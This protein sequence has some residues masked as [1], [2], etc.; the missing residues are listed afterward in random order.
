MGLLMKIDNFLP[1]TSFSALLNNLINM[2]IFL[3]VTPVF[4]TYGILAYRR[5]LSLTANLL[6]LIVS[7]PF[8]L[9]IAI[10]AF[11]EIIQGW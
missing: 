2:L 8:H 9:L 3:P 11:A 5:K 10:I 1:G 7:I 4:F 6:L